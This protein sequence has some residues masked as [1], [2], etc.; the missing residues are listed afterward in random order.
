MEPL[1]RGFGSGQHGTVHPERGG[2]AEVDLSSLPVER[3]E[4]GFSCLVEGA[5]LFDRAHDHLWIVLL[6]SM[7]GKLVFAGPYFSCVRFTP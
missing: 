5:A 4:Q 7:L 2:E 3:P 6:S 1:P